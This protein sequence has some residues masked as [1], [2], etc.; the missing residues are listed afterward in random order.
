MDLGDIWLFPKIVININSE[1]VH[2]FKK[3]PHREQVFFLYF[4]TL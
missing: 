3:R 2:K 1:L 4:R